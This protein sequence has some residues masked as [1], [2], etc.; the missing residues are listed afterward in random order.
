MKV[1]GVCPRRQKILGTAL[2]NRLERLEILKMLCSLMRLIFKTR[3]V[4]PDFFY[5]LNIILSFLTAVKVLTKSVRGNFRARTSLIMIRMLALLP[6]LC[7]ITS[8]LH[9]EIRIE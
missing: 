5:V 3:S 4:I 8:F 2:Q 6:F 1:C 7:S 9:C